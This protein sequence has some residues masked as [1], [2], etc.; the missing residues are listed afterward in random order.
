MSN[1]IYKFFTI[2]FL[3]LLITSCA[4]TDPYKNFKGHMG[5]N[6]GKNI[7][8]APNYSWRYNPKEIS[9]PLPNGNIEYKYEHK[10]RKG[11]CRYIFEV[12]P[13]TRTIVNWRYDGEDKDKA[14]YV[15]P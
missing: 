14:C 2:A 4:L 6:I 1:S 8:D 10:N 9:D 15:N 3:V 7:D 5:A 13:K 12:D 11:T